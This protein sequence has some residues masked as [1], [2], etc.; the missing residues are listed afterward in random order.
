VRPDQESVGRVREVADEHAIEAGPLV[1]RAVSAITSASKGGPDGGISSD[2]TR[3]A[4][5]PISSAG[6][7]T[8]SSARG[9]RR[10]TFTVEA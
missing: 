2:E 1:V 10:Q 9:P 8:P 5:Q 3:G 7:A 4:I 6:T